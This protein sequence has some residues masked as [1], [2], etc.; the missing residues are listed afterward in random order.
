MSRSAARRASRW[1]RL[2]RSRKSCCSS[3]PAKAAQLEAELRVDYPDRDFEIIAG[4]CNELIGPV[5]QRLRR[6]GWRAGRQ[7]FTLLDQHAAEITWSTLEALSTFNRRETAKVELWL[8]FAPS[9]LP[10]G[11]A[12][13]DA[14]S[15]TVRRSH[16]RDVRHR[17]LAGALRCSAAGADHRRRLRDELLNLMRW[18]LENVLG[19]RVTHSFRMRNTRDLAIYNMVFATD[20]LAG[21]KIMSHIYRTAAEAQPKCEPKQ[22]PSF[23]RARKRSPGGWDSSISRLGLSSTSTCTSTSRRAPYQL[24]ADD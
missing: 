12:G 3:C 15:R 1:P 8:L 10:R 24:P 20:H 21:E 9:M 14:D 19:Y 2:R 4:N 23:E 18:R 6:D 17:G 7:T 22:S 11:L 16:H 13:V 5:L